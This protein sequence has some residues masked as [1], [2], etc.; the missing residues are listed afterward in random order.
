MRTRETWHGV[1]EEGGVQ[2]Q[3]KQER[4]GSTAKAEGLAWDRMRTTDS[5]VG[6]KFKEKHETDNV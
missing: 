6:K 3:R 2:P 4:M 1:Q 5:Q